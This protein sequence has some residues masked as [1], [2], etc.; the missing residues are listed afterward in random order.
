MIFNM[1]ASGGSDWELLAEAHLGTY[2]TTSTSSETISAFDN[3]LLI[4]AKA[5]DI[6]S[7]T[8]CLVIYV[9]DGNGT[10]N[11]HFLA[12]IAT[13]LFNASNLDATYR[14]WNSMYS[15]GYTVKVDD[16]GNLVTATAARLTA[17]YGVY[18]YSCSAITG[19]ITFRGRTSNTSGT[20]DGDFYA[21]AYALKAPINILGE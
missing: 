9:V 12:S 3:K 20:V 4:P 1:I 7:Y 21:Y 15:A 2:S 13:C 16:S 18:I 5:I 19:A 10:R 14:T 17:L 11:G 6:E 8:P